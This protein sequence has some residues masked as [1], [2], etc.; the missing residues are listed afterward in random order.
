M[1]PYLGILLGA[2]FVESFVD[3][4]CREKVRPSIGSVVYCDLVFGR[5]EHSGIYVGDDKIV[6]LDGSGIIEIVSMK[7]FLN[8][9]NG[10]NSA[11][12]LYVSS[13]G[14]YS[15]GSRE[16]AQRA[17]N[18]IGS[19]RNYNL[20]TNNCHQFTSGC[21]TGNFENNDNF[22]WLLKITSENV[23]GSDCWRVSESFGSLS[24]N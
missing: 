18:M 21:L 10:F 15:V 20:L 2:N 23:L 3:N 13:C 6:H 9:L 7:K 12:S 22:L 16:V 1:F 5:A 8:R 24:L 4:V 19:R 14:C 17:L 11:I